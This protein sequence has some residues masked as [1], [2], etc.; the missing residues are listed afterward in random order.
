MA[1]TERLRWAGYGLVAATAILGPWFFG[2]TERWWFWPFFALLCSGVFCLALAAARQPAAAGSQPATRRLWLWVAPFMAYATVRAALAPVHMDAERSLLLFVTPLM[3]AGCVLHAFTP[4]QRVALYVVTMVNLGALGVYGILNHLLN[5]SR[6]VLWAAGFPQYYTDG[7]ASGSYYCPD[8]FSGIMEL[9]CAAGLGFV[10]TRRLRGGYR[11]AALALCGLAAVGVVLSKSRGGG[12]T[13][14]LLAL[15]ALVWG[16]NQ[17]PA[18]VRWL[19]RFSLAA[20]MA[21]VVT[22]VWNTPS[23]YMLRFKEHF[24]WPELRDAGPRQLLRGAL[25]RWGET[26][27]GLMSAASL[28]AWRTAPVFGVGPGMHRNVWPQFAATPDG[29]REEGLWPSQLNNHFHSYEAHND[30]IQLLEEY[31]I[32][33]AVLFLIAAG[34]VTTALLRRL[35]REG[36]RR[37]SR[38]SSDRAPDSHPFVLGGLFA[39]V[40]MAFHSLGDFNL[41]LPAT[42]WVLAVLIAVPLAGTLDPTGEPA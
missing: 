30:W 41:Q 2:A 20:A 25:T 1:I 31:G 34:A 26:P 16:F 18:G 3:I 22:V 24:N 36:S 4:T 19:N 9:A 32:V 10:F 42:T 12:L 7:R 11:L 8:H 39:L 17:W 35:R 13:L 38:R 29:S 40:A 28:R 33:G 27:R 23:Q 5:G 21:I 6:H 14:V 15:S 37:S